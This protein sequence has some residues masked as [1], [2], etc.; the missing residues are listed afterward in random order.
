MAQQMENARPATDCTTRLEEVISLYRDLD[1]LYAAMAVALSASSATECN[2]T[3]QDMQATQRKAREIDLQI[4]KD[5]ENMHA[6]P[7]AVS[8]LLD[9]RLLLLKRL[10]G[11]NRLIKNKANNVQSLLQHE[12]RAMSTGQNAMKGYGQTITKKNII[13]SSY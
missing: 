3:I 13:K 10:D 11:H 2:Q 4:A 7:A 5:L 1:Q 6:L 12:I 9:Q 8:N